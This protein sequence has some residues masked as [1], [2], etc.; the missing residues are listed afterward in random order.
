MRIALATVAVLVVL[1]AAAS[2]A[3][4]N[5]STTRSERPTVVVKVSHGFYWT[6]AL[7]G[8]AAAFGGLLAIAGGVRVLRHEGEEKR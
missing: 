5:G 2:S 8:A 7:I 4:D 6:D 3:A 1:V